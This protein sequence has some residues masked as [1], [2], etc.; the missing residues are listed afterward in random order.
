MAKRFTDTDIWK[1]QRWFRKLKPDYKLAFCYIK[2]SCHHS[3][4]WK[5]DCSDLIDDLGLDEF[6]FE[7]FVD[8]INTDFDKITGK[9][10]KKDRI[11]IVKNYLWITGFIQFQYEGKDK[12]VNYYAAPVRTALLFLSSVDILNEALSKGYI[13][14]TKPLEEGW[15]RP[16]DK[17]KDINILKVKNSE[18]GNKKNQPINFRAQGENLFIDRISKGEQAKRDREKN[19][20]VAS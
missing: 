14:L 11:R 18:N 9:V 6:D 3:G 17:E 13:T 15:E 10:V 5:I 4:L 2:D 19:S 16:K 1:N 12:K 8:F 7:K 20:K